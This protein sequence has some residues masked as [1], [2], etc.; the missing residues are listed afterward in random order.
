MKKEGEKEEDGEY[1][2]NGSFKYDSC[3]SPSEEGEGE[4]SRQGL[5]KFALNKNSED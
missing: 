3:A 5:S 2:S 4:G 1:E